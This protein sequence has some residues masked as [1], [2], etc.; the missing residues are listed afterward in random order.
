MAGLVISVTLPGR[1]VPLTWSHASLRV[2]LPD[3]R[4]HVRTEPADGSVLRPRAVPCR[5]RGHG[6]ASVHGGRGWHRLRGRARASGRWRRRGRLL[7]WRVLRLGRSVRCFPRARCG[8]PRPRG[9]S[10]TSIRPRTPQGSLHHARPMRSRG[11][12]PHLA[13]SPKRPRGS[14]PALG[15]ARAGDLVEG[16]PAPYRGAALRVALRN[17][18]R[19]R[20]PAR[21]PRSGSTAIVGAAQSASASSPWPGRRPWSAARRRSASSR[22]L[23]PINFLASICHRRLPARHVRPACPVA[24]GVRDSDGTAAGRKR[25]RPSATGVSTSAARKGSRTPRFPSTSLNPGARS[26]RAGPWNVHPAILDR[27]ASHRPDDLARTQPSR[28]SRNRPS[29]ISTPFDVTRRE[30]GEALLPVS[31]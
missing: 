12:A 5:A 28:P 29:V 22:P 31:A 18:R 13:A 21:T 6:E 27:R 24:G 11:L 19:I 8:L 17:S 15:F 7:W 10:R 9:G 2:P 30:G 14:S 16:A 3:V 26:W 1:A 4:R 23:V 25:M 20:S